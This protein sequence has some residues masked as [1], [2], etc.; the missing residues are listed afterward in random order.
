MRKVK[1]L[2]CVLLIDDDHPTN[3]LHKRVIQNTGIDVEVQSL[4]SAS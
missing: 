1:D 2:D 3:F 4:T